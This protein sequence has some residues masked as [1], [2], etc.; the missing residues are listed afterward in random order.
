MSDPAMSPGPP[1]LAATIGEH[2]VTSRN[3]LLVIACVWLAG[4]TCLGQSPRAEFKFDLGPGPVAPGY[5]KVLPST[6]YIKERGFGFEPGSK[7][8]GVDRGGSDPLRDDYCTGDG[9][10][11]FSVVLPEGNYEVK[12]TLGDSEGES[13][14]TVKAESRRLMVEGVHTRNGFY[15]RPTF[16]VN[17]RIPAIAS[18][19]NVKLKSREAGVSHWDDKLTL[20]FN[21][22]RP[23]VCGIEIRKVDDAVTVYL[24]GDSTVTDQTREPWNSWGQMLPRFFGPGVAVANHAESGESLKS[25]AGSGR[26]DKIM[27]TIK[28]GD[29]LFVQFGHND[30]KERGPGVGAFTTYKESLKHFVAEARGRRALPVLVTPVARRAFGTDGQV[31]NNLGDYPEAVRQVAKEEN[32]P[33]IDLNAMSKPF[34]EALGVEGSKKAFVDNTHHNNYGSYELARCIVEGIKKEKLGL[35]KFLDPS[36]PPL[37]PSHPD[38][39]ASFRVPASPQASTIVPD[40]S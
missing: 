1:P 6:V 15:A 21:D 40:G 30:Q 17:V 27:S 9:P 31:I 20:E 7:V 29:Y 28:P 39:I 4:P 22:N 8:V 12:L 26:L 11:L 5:V 10:F 19:G 37:D 13:I 32:V 25:F 3:F 24:A 33:L 14:T 34:Y 2:D 36:L 38:P 16:L 35:A 23:C 18:G